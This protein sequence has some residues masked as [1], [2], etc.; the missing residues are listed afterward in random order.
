MYMVDKMREIADT[1]TVYDQKGASIQKDWERTK[2]NT[3]STHQAN[4]KSITSKRDASLTEAKR[5]KAAWDDTLDHSRD[6]MEKMQRKLYERGLFSINASLSSPIASRGY[7]GMIQELTDMRRTSQSAPHF[8]PGDNEE[9]IAHMSA[10]QE[11]M[12][13]FK[14]DAAAVA[15]AAEQQ[16]NEENEFARRR[17]ASQ[18]AQEEAEFTRLMT[19]AQNRYQQYKTQ[20][21]D[22]LVTAFSTTLDPQGMHAM[23]ERLHQVIPTHENYVP[24]K[25]FPDEVCF[26]YAGYD[27]TDELDDECKRQALS[28][29]CGYMVEKLGRRTYLKFPYGYGFA[30]NRF[31]SMFQF[32]QKTRDEMVTHMQSMVMRLMM[33]V[34]CG[35]AWLTMIDPFKRAET[36][37]MFSPW[38]KDDERV[39]DTRIW[40]E[41][42]RI[43]ERLQTI[44]SHISDIHQR[45]L[46]GR[47]ENILE[48]NASAGKNAEPLRFLVIM[49]FPRHFTPA[50][51]DMLESIV[52]NGATT[53]VYALIAADMDAVAESMNPAVQRICQS[54]NSFTL[55]E[56]AMFTSDV[57]NNRPLRFLP[58]SCVNDDIVFDTIEKIRK[59]ILESDRITIDLTDIYPDFPKGFQFMSYDA[60]NGISI[61]IGL[62]GANKHVR[63]ELGGKSDGG[64]AHNYHAMIGGTIG[65]GK[66]TL[67]HNIITNILMTYSPDEVQMYLV[68]LKDGVEFKRYAQH[69]N[70]AHLR[71]VAINAEKL[72]A[73]SVLRDLVNE[74]SLRAQKFRG[75]GTNRIEAYNKLMRDENRLDE[76]MPRLVVVMDEV[77]GLFDKA[78]DPITQECASLLETLILMGGSAFGIQMILATQDWANVVGLK[79]S[80]YNNIGVRIALKNNPASAATIL[81]SDNEII[82]RLETYDTGKAVFNG[83]TGHKDYN[84]EFR[85][86]RIEDNEA[87]QILDHL[88]ALQRQNANLRRPANQRLL[89]ADINDIEA[90][91]LTVLAKSNTIARSR[92]MSYRLWM[93]DG[94]SMVNTFYPAL[95]SA[96]GQNLLLVGSKEETAG[97]I[98]GFAAMSL[99]LET[100]RTEGAITRPVITLFDFSNPAQMAYGQ[101][102][103]L[104]TLLDLVPDA[105]RVFRGSDMLSGMQILEEEMNA[106][107]DEA[108]HFVIFFGINRARRLTE[109]STYSV[110][111]RDVLAR[112]VHEGPQ[113]GF[114]FIIWANAPAMF[115]QFYG[116]MLGDF[117]QRLIFDSTEDELYSYFVQDKKPSTMDERNALSYNLD[118]DN[119][120]VKLFS[121]PSDKWLHE[122]TEA[123][124]RHM[125]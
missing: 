124:K 77:Q 32:N 114:N 12:S 81:A 52:T 68:D 84:H 66:S 36:F 8:K 29:S 30:D 54:M 83:Y 50:A 87:H 111:P 44:I 63:L 72:F 27:I 34:P 103:L 105:F 10:A 3:E 37:S 15:H 88:E 122:F 109:G 51:L 93:G 78:D 13:R 59:G 62:E 123:V 101:K 56:E 70:L 116:D 21:N 55:H 94:L 82:S 7:A 43:E 33:S 42:N 53:G 108:Q 106:G 14:Q 121:I 65:S 28:A 76:I 107:A 9:L 113:K 25:A 92:S 73:L 19:D 115:Q 69:M 90:N 45:C 49:D 57:I 119:Q 39:I 89:S 112:L 41:E 61:P 47:Y 91:E 97:S 38:G 125:K 100:I 22:D 64:R 6:H 80:L 18:S 16:F 117:E 120:L 11:M 46:Q 75:S 2:S 86:T 118:G 74:Q 20:L 31:S 102:T 1:L 71:V 26:G 99:L 17:F 110:K 23:F 85:S 48:Y 104:H 60:S 79:E 24:P 58:M 5:R 67:L 95:S 96:V 98:A 4:I 40:H 35:K